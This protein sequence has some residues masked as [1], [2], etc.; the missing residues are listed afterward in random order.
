MN[1]SNDLADDLP[2]VG[3]NTGT[4]NRTE[5]QLALILS[6]VSAGLFVLSSLHL[7]GW[8]PGILY[9]I[10]EQFSLFF[11][12]TIIPG[13]LFTLGL[14]FIRSR[15]LLVTAL[16]ASAYI[17]QLIFWVNLVSWIGITNL[18]VQF[19]YSF[20]PFYPGLESFSYRFYSAA[21]VI[22]FFIAPILMLISGLSGLKTQNASK[23]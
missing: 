13:M 21:G 11:R 4:R 22:K 14:V 3:M 19:N 20:N 1:E 15:P 17:L 10:T 5:N 7:N 9:S 18:F 23:I 2:K 16:G 8:F 6:V 12:F